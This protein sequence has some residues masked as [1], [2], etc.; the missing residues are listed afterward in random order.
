MVMAM[1]RRCGCIKVSPTRR[2]PSQRAES[3]PD[4]CHVSCSST[5]RRPSRAEFHQN[6]ID[7]CRASGVRLTPSAKAVARH[8]VALDVIL[9]PTC[10]A[11]RSC[12]PA[13]FQASRLTRPALC[14]ILLS[15]PRHGGLPASLR[16]AGPSALC[17]DSSGVD[18]PPSLQVSR[19]P[20]LGGGA[21]FNLN[22]ITE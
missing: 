8:P 10:C 7:R 20:G 3:I 11:G 5:A 12:P 21:C 6:H 1:E 4:E 16:P 9:A 17:P 22:T 2:Q 13:N 14:I 19:Y 15:H 18:L